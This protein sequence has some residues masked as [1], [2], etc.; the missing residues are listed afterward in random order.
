MLRRT[1][2]PVIKGKLSTHSFNKSTCYENIHKIEALKVEINELKE[3][4]KSTHEPLMVIYST[5]IISFIST[6]I[7][8]CK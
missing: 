4:I 3:L 2:L 6:L 1:I 5:S 8:V 7:L